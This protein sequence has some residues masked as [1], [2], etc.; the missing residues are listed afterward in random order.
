[1]QSRNRT[2]TMIVTNSSPRVGTC[3]RNTVL[4]LILIL[5]T[6]TDTTV[7]H[8]DLVH[9]PEYPFFRLCN[10][11]RVRVTA[12]HRSNIPTY[13]K[14]IL[15]KYLVTRNDKKLAYSSLIGPKYCVFILGG[16]ENPKRSENNMIGSSFRNVLLRLII[17]FLQ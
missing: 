11:W 13:V 17:I 1:M 6:Y 2:R 15:S 10:L 16:L 12:V 3:W 5:Y 7:H 14:N 4:S 8:H 9:H